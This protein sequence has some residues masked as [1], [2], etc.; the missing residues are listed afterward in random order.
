[1]AEHILLTENPKPLNQ[2]RKAIPGS[3]GVGSIH[4]A[5]THRWAHRGIRRKDG[6]LVK[7]EV[8]RIGGTVMSSEAAIRRFL[9]AINETGDDSQQT[10][11]TPSAKKR[12]AERMVKSLDEVLNGRPV[13][14]ASA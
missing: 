9:T 8:I 10:S 14:C 7:L 4:L 2:L 11:P 6:T 1:M 5:T 12:T 3:R 13:A